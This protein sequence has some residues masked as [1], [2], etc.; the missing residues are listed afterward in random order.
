MSITPIFGNLAFILVACSFMVKDMLWLRALSITASLC[1]IFYNAHVAQTPLLVPIS[2]NL[3][4][5]ALNLFHIARLF[6]GNRRIHLNKKELE[7][8]Q[9][10]FGDLNLQEFAKL[11]SLGQWKVY[12]PGE[13]LVEENQQM[14]DLMMISSGRVDILVQKKK[15]GELRDGQFIGEMSYLAGQKASASVVAQ[16]ETEVLCWKQD[17]LKQLKTKNP[18]LI[19]SLQGAMARQ[20]TV[21][22]A[23]KNNEH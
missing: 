17:E 22:L 8:Y 14:V 6:Y 7:L 4:F 21:V 12:H 1:S 5:I 18:S 2:W 20:L 11:L 10:S 15:V 16:F 13:V 19:F 23:Q 3:F 9:L